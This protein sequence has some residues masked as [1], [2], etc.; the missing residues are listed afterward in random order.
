MNLP[1]SAI[2]DLPEYTGVYY[3]MDQ[4]GKVIY[5][6]KALNIKSRVKS[7][8]FNNSSTKQKQEF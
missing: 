2:E 8:F 5:V 4:K 6:G 1:A 7:H 3:F